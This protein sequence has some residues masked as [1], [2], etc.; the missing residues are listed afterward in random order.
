MRPE[1][2]PRCHGRRRAA[3]IQSPARHGRP[4]AG[5]LS[6]HRCGMDGR[7]KA[8]RDGG[9]GLDHSREAAAIHALGKPP[10]QRVGGRPAPAMT[11]GR[12]HRGLRRHTRR[13][14]VPRRGPRLP[15]RQRQTE[16]PARRGGALRRYRTRGRSPP[17]RRG[18]ARRPRP[19]L[20]ASP[21]PSEWGGRG[22]TP[23]AAGDLQP[24]GG[25]VRRAARRLRDRPRHVHPDHDAPTP[26]RSSCSATCRP[27]LRGEEIWCQLFSEP[28]GRLRPRRP[29]HARRARGRRR[30]SSTARRSGPPARTTADF[31]MLLTR[32]DPNVPKHKGLTVVLPR[33]EVAGHRDP[34]DQPDVRRLATSTRCSSP[35][36]ASP[37]S[38]GSAPSA[39]AGRWRSPR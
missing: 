1:V 6:H 39:R 17:P 21:G 19:A 34:A 33:H 11:R 2:T 32:T 29:A 16:G 5:H 26:N 28:A 27:A 13:S 24:G 37:T 3:V 30:G 35:T 38:S 9:T 20:P 15:R 25:A 22:G 31:G 23:I 8:G 36:C 14:R 4:C 7:H 10:Q 12:L 18:S